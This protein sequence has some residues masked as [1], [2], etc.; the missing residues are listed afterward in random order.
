MARVA[1]IA[2]VDVTLGILLKAQ[3]RAQR[4][5]GF[6][7]TTISAPG[8]WA[9]ELEA[10]GIRHV[11]WRHATRAWNPKDDARAF[12]ELYSI[13]GHERFDIVHTHTPKPGVFG[14]ISA[15]L[16][17]VP[18]VVNTV[19]GFVASPD[20]PLH[21]RAFVMGCEWLAA[22]FSDLEL[23]QSEADLDRA[24]KLWMVGRKA[25]LI[26]NGTDLERFDPTAVNG[27]GAGLR[28]HLGIPESSFVVG[29]IGR[30]V[31]EKGYR[32]FFSAARSVRADT[33]DVR[34]VV[35]GDADPSKPDAIGAGELEAARRDV[36]FTGWRDDVPELL[37]LFDV[38]VLASWREGF[39]RSAIE[40]AAM[41]KPLVLS[42]IPGCREV[43]RDGSEA[44]FV[45]PRDAAALTSAIRDLITDPKRTATMGRNAR[46]RA[47]AR[48]DEGQIARLTIDRYEDLLRRRRHAR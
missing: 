22:R 36:I 48:F 23:Y 34:F 33:P 14:R 17:G 26:G 4:D 28:R 39:P 12:V 19:H 32:E 10:E 6:E 41:G 44:I 8:P 24:R 31:A 30:I 37:S 7:V 11:P 9:S 15:R 20:Q 35:V 21:R 27:D 18:V 46:A 13:L 40:A 47:L 25:V 38:F 29:T 1:H 3:L 45:P 42:D 16:R 2:T 43:A 5:A